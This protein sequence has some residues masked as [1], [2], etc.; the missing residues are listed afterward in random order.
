MVNTGFAQTYLAMELHLYQVSHVEK[1]T[2]QM[3][4]NTKSIKQSFFNQ[5]I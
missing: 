1:F 2:V 5:F 3:K 4:K